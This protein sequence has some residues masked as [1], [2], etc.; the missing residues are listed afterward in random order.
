MQF[1]NLV[2]CALANALVSANDGGGGSLR[3]N[4]GDVHVGIGEAC[5]AADLAPYSR[6]AKLCKDLGP[7]GLDVGLDDAIHV[8]MG[9]AAAAG[10][11]SAFRVSELLAAAD[12]EA[13]LD[14]L[15]AAQT[16]QVQR[17]LI[18]DY[19]WCSS[20]LGF[21]TG[22]A[23]DTSN[24]CDPAQDCDSY[25]GCGSTLSQ[26]CINHDKCLQ[27]PGSGATSRCEEADCKGLTCDANLS[28]C[29]WGVSCCTGDSWWSCDL[30]CTTMSS[31]ISAGFGIG[32]SSPQS[33]LNTGGSDADAA[34]S[35]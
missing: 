3:A 34:C 2:V 32:A 9:D 6:V 28:S 30:A 16:T 22:M 15:A 23:A 10:A 13:A 24:Y 14:A 17:R 21:V 8:T 26:C 31:G 25:G 18:V 27:V 12:P 7:G 1:L 29:A 20:N 19:G 5:A 4:L 11:V 33:A 35:P